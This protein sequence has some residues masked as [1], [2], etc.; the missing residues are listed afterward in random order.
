VKNQSVPLVTWNMDQ[1]NSM[2]YKPFVM[3]LHKL[4]FILPT[5]TKKMFVRIPNFWSIRNMH[6]IALEL[7]PID[8]CE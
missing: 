4:G 1:S 7:G 3:L 2:S 8:K 5:A 6:D